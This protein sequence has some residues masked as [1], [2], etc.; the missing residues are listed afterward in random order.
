MGRRNWNLHG[1]ALFE[2]ENRT[3]VRLAVCQKSGSDVI[4]TI[5]EFAPGFHVSSLAHVLN[6]LHPAMV[7][8]LDLEQI[9]Q[10]IFCDFTTCDVL[11]SLE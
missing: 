7:K 11:A 2:H 8:A 9:L 3:S 4:A 5:H 1:A 6:R 10:S